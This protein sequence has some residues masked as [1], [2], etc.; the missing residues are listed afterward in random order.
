MS[1]RQINLLNILTILMLNIAFWI[2]NLYPRHILEFDSVG[3]IVSVLINLIFFAVFDYAII[4]A[5]SENKSLFSHDI[6]KKEHFK[7]LAVLLVIQFLIDGVVCS[8][9]ALELEWRYLITDALIAVQWI[10]GYIVISYRKNS[11]FK[12]GN[13][14]A[15]SSL[16]FAVVWG[17]SAFL[18][19]AILSEYSVCALK[20]EAPS[21]VLA[22]AKS[23][24]EFIYGAKSLL[25]DSVLGVAVVTA[26]SFALSD[27]N[28]EREEKIKILFRVFVLLLAI[29]LSVMSKIQF[30]H[31]GA[32]SEVKSTD[33]EYQHYSSGEF[34]SRVSRFEI[35][36][37]SSDS[38][39]ELVYSDYNINLEKEGTELFNADSPD[40]SAIYTGVIKELSVGK[41]TVFI[42]NSQ[43]ICFYENGVPRAVGLNDLIN[44]EKN[45]ILIGVCKQLLENGNV[46]AFEYCKDYLLKY[47]KSFIAGYIE[48]YSNG[49]FTDAESKWMETNYFKKQF[50]TDF[51]RS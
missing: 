25:L 30:W 50:V 32:I 19:T 21:S 31:Y 12:K 17:I 26:H 34:N 28:R 48:R 15:I 49:E 33:A 35:Y 5:F 24:A 41:E 10:V 27:G 14:L 46:Y 43:V 16:A 7:K 44:C 11:V 37:Y 29:L 18:N 51:A 47:D 2:C 6:L 8:L 4:L 39:E 13:L 9:G 42:H 40:D 45:D 3:S 20:Y 36:R 23:N 1:K 22:M 38:K